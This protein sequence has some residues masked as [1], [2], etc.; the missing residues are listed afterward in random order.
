MKSLF[1]ITLFC[2]VFVLVWLE[3]SSPSSAVE[4][5]NLIE[6]DDE[7]V[8]EKVTCFVIEFADIQMPVAKNREK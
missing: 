7:G 1:S 2:K 5:S 8:S 4:K 3:I 6:K